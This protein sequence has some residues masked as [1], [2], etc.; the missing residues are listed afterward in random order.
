MRVPQS[1]KLEL[2]AEKDVVLAF[3]TPIIYIKG[4]NTEALN[5]ELTELIQQKMVSDSGVKKSNTG[6]HSQTDLT[7]WDHPAIGQMFGLIEPVLRTM[8]G[9]IAGKAPW[10]GKI[11]ISAWANVNR[12]NQY[13][14]IHNHPGYHWS[15]VYYVEMG[16]EDDE[17]SDSGKIEFQDPRGFASMV[18]M[19]GKP[20]GQTMSLKPKAGSLLIF[21]SF[22]FHAVTPYIGDGERI[23]I[24]FNASLLPS[25]ATKNW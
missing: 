19:P 16:D 2:S 7:N 24:A 15:G 23:S 11:S 17:V 8:S 1:A 12:K 3:T 21:P 6:W 22:L 18:P 5:A 20:F 13:N 9:G 14:K 4:S 25:E 10:P